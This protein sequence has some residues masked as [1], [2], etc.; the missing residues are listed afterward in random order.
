MRHFELHPFIPRLI[1]MDTELKIG[2]ST[3]DVGALIILS[4]AP[5]NS[6]LAF[7][8]PAKLAFPEIS[9]NN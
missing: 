3:R 1:A 9:C 2:M 6:G 4:H 5:T 8:A 7:K